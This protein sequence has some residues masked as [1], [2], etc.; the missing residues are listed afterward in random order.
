MARIRQSRP[1]Y[2]LGFQ[3]KVFQI[4]EIL[5]TT[6]SSSSEIQNGQKKTDELQSMKGFGLGGEG[7][8][9]I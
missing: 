9:S 3:V 2:G 4:L 7:L 6:T 5:V 1:G 8:G